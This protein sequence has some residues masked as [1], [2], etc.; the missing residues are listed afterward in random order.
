MLFYLSHEITPSTQTQ[1]GHTG[2]LSQCKSRQVA[3]LKLP[4]NLQD[5][6][7]HCIFVF[8][9]LSH[10]S[11]PLFS[12]LSL[13][14]VD[15]LLVHR[16]LTQICAFMSLPFA[17]QRLVLLSHKDTPEAGAKSGPRE[18]ALPGWAHPLHTHSHTLQTQR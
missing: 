14:K 13:S 9:I 16:P 4:G 10:L 12:S 11:L 2:Y 15:R 5:E 7:T 18:P 8:S 6:G 17:S 1:N 3:I